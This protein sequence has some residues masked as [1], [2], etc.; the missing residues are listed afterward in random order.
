DL[1]LQSFTSYKTVAL[2]PCLCID[3]PVGSPGLRPATQRQG[4]SPIDCATP[5]TNFAE[6]RRPGSDGAS[7]RYATRGAD[8][9]GMESKASGR[10]DRPER[11]ASF[12]GSGSPPLARG[13]ERTFP[14]NEAFLESIAQRKGGD[15]TSPIPIPG[16]VA[17]SG[18]WRTPG[19][20]PGGARLPAPTAAAS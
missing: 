20:R 13:D 10:K 6:E 16:L 11:A 18:D 19:W 14:L 2:F 4:L 12:S 7:Y 1:R 15:T 8:K 17:S 9:L 5:C 3:G